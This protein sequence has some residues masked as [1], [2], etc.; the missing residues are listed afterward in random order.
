MLLLGA[1]R[2]DPAPQ[3]MPVASD[4]PI[5]FSSPQTK[6]SDELSTLARLAT[7]KFGVCAWY[8]PEGETFGGTGSVPYILN[9]RFGCT[10]VPSYT[11][12]CGVTAGGAA[13]P[14]YYPLDGTLSYFCYAPFRESVTDA[15]DVYF[16][17]N[18]DP[19]I[20]TQLANYMPGS[21][22]IRFTPTTSTA[23]QIDFIVAPPVLDI[24]RGDG[25]VELDFTKHVTT[26]IEFWCKYAGTLDAESEGVVIT[27]LVISNVISSEYLYYTENAGNIGL[28]WCSNISPDPD[29]E[30]ETPTMPK[31]SY[32]LSTINNSLITSDA[33]LDVSTPKF[34]NETNNGIIYMLPQTLPLAASL[35]VTYQVRIKSTGAVLDENTVSIPLAGTADWPLGKVVKYTIT[36]GVAARKDVELDAEILR[37]SNARN[38]HSEQELM[39]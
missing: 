35:D 18:P 16:I 29:P 20:T 25:A 24:H 3:P 6:G 38:K 26:K 4:V 28:E 8:T 14:V 30:E 11:T 36:I 7:Q 17:P 31:A 9:H 22:L 19:A 1:C 13:N 39:Y 37:W 21:P 33:W 34:V 15:S 12:W 27:R 2:K 23:S 32:T 5:E 10:D